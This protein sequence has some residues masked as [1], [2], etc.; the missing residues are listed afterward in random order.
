M[1]ANVINL[2]KSVG[3]VLGLLLVLRLI[4]RLSHPAPAWPPALSAAQQ[5]AA[6][7][8]HR[9]LYACMLLLPLAGYIASN[10]SKHGVRFFGLKLDPW[11][12][13]DPAL[14][15]FFNGAHG[16]LGFALSVLVAGHVL[17]ALYHALVRK[18]GVWERM[19]PSA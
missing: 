17:A 12:A 15:A 10:F 2:H 19:R 6:L 18:D 16:L 1:R 3:M 7:W 5:R 4:W 14:Y 8:G 13:D 9:A 11:G